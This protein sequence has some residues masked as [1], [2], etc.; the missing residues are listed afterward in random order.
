MQLV[1]F[2]QLPLPGNPLD[3]VLSNRYYG[4][5]VWHAGI[6]MTADKTIF[7]L[8]FR[9][10]E[11][12]QPSLEELRNFLANPKKEDKGKLHSDDLAAYRDLLNAVESFDHGRQEKFHDRMLYGVLGHSQLVEPALKLAV[13]QYKFHVHTLSELDLK[14]PSAFITSAK[15]EIARLN[16]KKKDEAARKERLSG[17]VEERQ[18]TLNAIKKHCHALAEELG[19]IV[20][21]I[22]DNLVRIEK[23]SEESIVIL[24]SDQIGKKKK[25][26]LIE[27]IKTQFKE[28]LRESLHQGTITQEQLAAVKEEVA[29]LTK[30]TSD[31]LRS[32]GYTL[33]QLYEAIHEY[34]KKISRKLNI[35]LGD[36]ERKKHTSYD[37]D[38]ELYLRAEKI[39]VSLTHDCCFEIPAS[40]TGTETEHEEILIEKEGR[41]SITSLTCCEK[42]HVLTR[43][44]PRRWGM[45]E[46]PF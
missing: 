19:H 25:V 27:D 1:H 39:L 15:D 10:N 3:P 24:V 44:R 34:S 43:T 18:R 2:F 14:K 36:I 7:G 31:L 22:R 33:A 38:R 9:S 23:L 42:G 21:Y 26:D 4:A 37:E 41:C 5:Q 17:M 28:R 45:P 6:P 16:P 20:A 35:V 12:L 11:R 13:E 8:R 40:D 30:R 29:G 46:K 32:D